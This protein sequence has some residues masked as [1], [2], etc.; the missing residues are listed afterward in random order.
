MRWVAAEKSFCA[1]KALSTMT[2]SIPALTAERSPLLRILD[3]NHFM[4]R[5]AEQFQPF[6]IGIGV[7]F[8]RANSPLQSTNS[9]ESVIP[10]PAW[11]SSKSSRRAEV[12]IPIR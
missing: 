5:A 2:Q 12:T 1:V 4:L 11:I 3:E 9:M 8:R 6:Q 7:G 10:L